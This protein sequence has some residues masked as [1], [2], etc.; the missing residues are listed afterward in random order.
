MIFQHTLAQ[1]L[2]G[3]KTQ[4]RRRMKSAPLIGH[5]YSIQPN[6][7][8]KGI[9]RM[10][11]VAVREERVGDISEEDA[12]KEG[13]ANRSAFLETWA[14]IH[15]LNTEEKRRRGFEEVVY[16][17]TFELVTEEIV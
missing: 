14:K 3:Q 2:S 10:R 11:V 7:G 8:M 13:F 1:V 6:R 5:S 4:T 15:K 17:V 12:I 16:V 9:A